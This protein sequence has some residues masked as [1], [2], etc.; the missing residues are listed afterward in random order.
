MVK[1]HWSVRVLHWVMAV[2]VIA[3]FAAVFY[4]GELDDGDA[5]QFWLDIHR[6]IGLGTLLLVLLRVAVRGLFGHDQVPSA[7]MPRWIRLGAAVSHFL[8][9]L[10]LFSIPV[11]GWL[12]SSAKARHFK[13]FDHTLPSLVA[14]NP[15]LADRLHGWHM[16]AAWGLLCLLA[17]HVLGA[18]Y[19]YLIR[20]DQ[21]L[22]SML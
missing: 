14:K 10:A 6:T 5:R 13:L 18:L 3:A 17:L 2:V 4:R 11:L 1:H 16:A 9:Y 20:R 21:V 19:H 12:L 7:S 8:L 22:Q 15:E